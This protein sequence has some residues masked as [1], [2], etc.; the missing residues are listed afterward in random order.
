MLRTRASVVE[1][2]Q[3]LG[4]ERNLGSIE[5]GKLADIVIVRADPRL[6]IELAAQIEVV[7]FRGQLSIGGR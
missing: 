2:P 5:E 7:V 6:N 4:Y 1:D 3:A